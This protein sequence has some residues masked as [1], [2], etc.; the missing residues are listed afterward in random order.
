MKAAVYH[1]KKN[2]VVEEVADK[3]AGPDEVVI[4]VKIC[5]VCGTDVHIYNGDGGSFEVNPPLIPGHEFSGVVIEVGE[6][7]KNVQVGDH[8]TGDPNIMCGKCY[9]CR[10]GIEHFCQDVKGVGTTV[11][12]GFAE[13][14][15]MNSSHVFKVPKEMDFKVAAMTEPISCCLHG[16]DLCNIKA[17]DTVLV[18]GGG[19]I[20]IIM[21]QLAKQSG[22]AKVILSEPVASKRELALSLGADLVVDPMTQDVAAFLAANTNNVDCVIECIG[23][24]YTMQDAINFA[25]YKATVMFFG[26]ASPEDIITLKPDTIFKKELRITSSFINPYTFPRAIQVLASGKLDVTSII[27]QIIPLENIVDVFTQPELRR[28]GK[29]VIQMP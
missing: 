4:Q 27:T 13:Q 26:L 17:G 12:G 11:D 19:P 22:A 9:Y 2:M 16:I 23:N 6:N 14:L 5:G 7:V 15:V 10:S 28:D 3:H 25:G 8:V 1:G 20:G 18:M 21:L 29:V 24:V